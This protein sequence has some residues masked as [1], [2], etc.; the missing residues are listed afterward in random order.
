M[1]PVAHIVKLEVQVNYESARGHLKEREDNFPDSKVFLPALLPLR[2]LIDAKVVDLK[3]V[4]TRL[5]YYEQD[6]EEE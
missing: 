6:L 2:P 5:E 3:N 1:Q 4:R